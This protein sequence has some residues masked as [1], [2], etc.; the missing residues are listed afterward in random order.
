MYSFLALF[1]NLYVLEILLNLNPPVSVI[2]PVDSTWPIDFPIDT[3]QSLNISTNV[4][5]H[6]GPPLYIKLYVA[7][8]VFVA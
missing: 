5:Q 3:S 6:A 7:N 1:I 2:I 4:K 8:S